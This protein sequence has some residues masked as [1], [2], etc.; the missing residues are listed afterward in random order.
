[1]KKDI[2]SFVTKGIVYILCG[3]L[4]G[5]FP[6]IVSWI[7]YIVGGI[8]IVSSIF[9]LLGGMN[10]GTD[11]T[12]VGGSLA[13]VIIGVIVMLIPKI[14]HIGI[15]IAAGIVFVISGIKRIAEAVKTD[16]GSLKNTSFV[17]GIAVLLFGCFLFFFPYR[18]GSIARIVIGLV[19]IAL[20]VFNFYVAH[21]AKQRSSDVSTD[22]IIDV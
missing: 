5:F 20:G 10:S 9:M 2:S 13:G 6:G 11:G 19:L 15:P 8:I 4:I 21:V 12:L 17:F 7:F 14:L 18:A 22:D 3:L 16:K 1:M